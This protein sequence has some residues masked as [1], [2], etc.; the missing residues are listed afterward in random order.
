[1]AI[2]ADALVVMAK[3][4][5][6]G[7]VKTRLV[8]PLTYEQAAEL[9]RALLL[10]QLRHLRTIDSVERYLAYAPADVEAMMREFGGAD[11]R[12]MPQR[13]AELGER[14]KNVFDDLWQR[15][16]KRIALVGS[17]LPALPTQII[18]QAFE[19][20]AG[21]ERRVVLGPSQDGGYYLVGM[22]Q[23]TPEI[24][25]NIIW[26]HD[27]VLAQTTARLNALNVSFTMLPIWYDLDSM[28]DLER[29]RISPEMEPGEVMAKT[30]SYLAE[31]SRLGCLK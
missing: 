26:S 7:T 28:E 21:D 17:D 23:A 19:R 2:R 1:M 10:D 9:Y 25:E 16:H 29:L 15:G 4:P 18:C 14:M 8:P 20:I 30:R 3:A 6:P 12:Y 11:Y 27:Q 5:V 31:L 13:G 24:F 22:N